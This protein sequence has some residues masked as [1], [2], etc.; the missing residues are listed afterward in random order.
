MTRILDDGG[1][2]SISSA[3]V[4]GLRRGMEMVLRI[5]ELRRRRL[6]WICR[7]VASAAS[8]RKEEEMNVVPAFILY[9][10][11]WTG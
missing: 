6:V 4:N 9:S 3:I 2:V 10:R 8:Y 5:R 1:F 11:S 7:E